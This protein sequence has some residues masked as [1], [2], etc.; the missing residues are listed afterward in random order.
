MSEIGAFEQLTRLLF[1]AVSIKSDVAVP[2]P[3]WRAKSA[4]CT[5]NTTLALRAGATL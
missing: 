1:L 5:S 3:Q 2:G 4:F